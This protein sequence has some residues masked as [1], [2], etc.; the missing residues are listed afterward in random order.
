MPSGVVAVGANVHKNRT[1]LPLTVDELT[2]ELTVT[3]VP[4]TLE[5]S[6]RVPVA[7]SE[8]LSVWT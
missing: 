2:G 6:A 5:K 3:P 7:A 8:N 4:V 1:L